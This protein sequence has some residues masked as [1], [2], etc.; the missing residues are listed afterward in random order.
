MSSGENSITPE[1]VVD[2]SPLIHLAAADRLDILRAV[3][4]R[5]VI[6]A[7][8]C[9]E[10]RTGG[11]ADAA[12]EAINRGDWFDEVPVPEISVS[13]LAW[14]IGAGESSVL[15][16]ALLHP[17]VLAVMDDWQGR[18]CAQ[19]LRIPVRGTLG[20][21][22]TAKRAG[23]IHAARPVVESLRSTGMY[24]SQVAMDAALALV[25]E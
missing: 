13:I 12:V 6:P 5:I 21:V 1:A 8:V 15:T 11:Y 18:Q 25:G 17:G 2:T 4:S 9:Q 14:D 7:A 20:L 22:L 3:A 10:I 24:L 19:T 16:Y 23:R